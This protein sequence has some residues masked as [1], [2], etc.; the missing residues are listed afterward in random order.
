MRD[1]ALSQKLAVLPKQPGV[2]L[3]KGRRGEVLYVGKAKV[4][5]H[6][7]RSYFRSGRPGHPRTQ[8]MVARVADIETMVTASELEALILENNLIKRHRPKYNVVLRDDK[9]Y[10]LLR[11]S[12][13]DDY[14]KLEKVRR[15]KADGARYFGP[16]VPAGGLNEMLR[17][18]QTIFPLP[19]C[20]IEIDGKLERPCIEYE[21]K[22]CLAPCTGQQSKADYREMIAEVCMFL[23]GRDKILLKRLKGLMKE[24]AAALDFEAAARLRDQSARVS[25]ALEQQR[26]TSSRIEDLDVMGFAQAQG[27]TALQILFIRGG[28]VIGKKEFFPEVPP[29]AG[30]AEICSAFLQQFYHKAG[31]IPGEILVPQPLPEGGVLEAWLRTRR[32]GPVRVRCPL[33]GKKKDLVALATENAGSALEAQLKIR[34][35]G[36]VQLSALQEMLHLKRRPERIEGYDIS[37]F[38]GTNAVGSMV[39]FE[40]GQPKKSDY[41]HFKIRTIEGAD[42]FGMMAEVLTRRFSPQAG[43]PASP[44]QGALPDLILIDGGKGQLSA[45]G[46]VLKAFKL[47]SLDLIG[48]AKEKGALGERVYLPGATEAIILPPGSAATHLLMQVRDEAHRFAVSYHRKIRAKAMLSTPLQEI[49]GI[50]PLR[51]KALLKHFGSLTKIREASLVQ[52]EAAPS[53]NKGIARKLHD[54][55]QAGQTE[56][57]S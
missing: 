4:L 40:G 22:R 55:F 48:L 10:P 54:A 38:M 9:N 31:I 34:S 23:E 36:H 46:A 6:R 16:Y 28:R 33:R 35:G 21:I 5:A 19:S 50:G 30:K 2:Y 25:R 41:R 18:L 43:E 17:L 44:P 1:Q 3:M 13:Q 7:V 32:S 51:R 26:I 8:A 29:G 12:I 14:P 39:V 11:L 57:A 20:S 47:A 53:M 45:V 15:I 37:N 24:R 27:L 56:P 52:L 42:D 49:K